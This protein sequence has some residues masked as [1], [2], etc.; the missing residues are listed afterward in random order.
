M[1]N[2]R[3]TIR[4]SPSLAARLA[5]TAGPRGNLADTVRHAIEAYLREEQPVRQPA[6][7]QGQTWQPGLTAWQP[8]RPALQEQ[9]ADFLR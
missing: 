8:S 7:G 6:P 5:A 2:P 4:L 9:R 1:P 3:I